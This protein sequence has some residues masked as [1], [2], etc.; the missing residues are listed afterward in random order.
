MVLK[1]NLYKISYVIFC[2]SLLS[3]TKD[4]NNIIIDDFFKV[5]ESQSPGE[6]VDYL[7]STNKWVDSS[8]EQVETIKSDLQKT[9]SLLGEY[10]EYELI[11]SKKINNS[12]VQY[13]Y[14][15]KYSRQPLRFTI[16]LY[17]PNEK[18]QV[19]NFHYDYNL[20]DELKDSSRL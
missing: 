12:I 5:Y 18:W 13:Q 16:V 17:K 15:V 7:F 4:Q 10:Y 6:A 2:L 11:S 9:I 1:N 14:L 19:Q 8:K 3:C 20:L